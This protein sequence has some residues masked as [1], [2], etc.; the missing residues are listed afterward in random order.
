MIEQDNPP[1]GKARKRLF[2]RIRSGLWYHRHEPIRFITLSTDDNQHTDTVYAFSKLVQHLRR[3]GYNFEYIAVFTNERNGVIHM[4]QVGDYIDWLYLKILWLDYSG[5]NRTDIR[6][7]NRKRKAE[8][9]KQ[10]EN[11]RVGRITSYIIGQYVGNQDLMRHVQFS[12]GWLPHGWRDAW[13]KSKDATSMFIGP[14]DA[15]MRLY[16]YSLKD[17]VEIYHKWLDCPTEP[18][19]RL[20]DCM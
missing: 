4:L 11:E 6:G 12:R 18:I 15:P 13:K 19:K 8:Y 16:G 5:C 20:I 1:R 9:A 14:E 17:S 2:H 3:A 10:S 7:A